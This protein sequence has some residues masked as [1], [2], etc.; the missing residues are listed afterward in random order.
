MRP[1]SPDHG[2]ALPARVDRGYGSPGDSQG[3]RS[4]RRALTGHPAAVWR[5]ARTARCHGSP[6]ASQA[7]S[8]QR[9]RPGTQRRAANPAHAWTSRGASAR[10]KRQPAGTKT[11]E[12][13]ALIGHGQDAADLDVISTCLILTGATSAASREARATGGRQRCGDHS[14]P[15]LAVPAAPSGKT[16]STGEPRGAQRPYP[17]VSGRVTRIRPQSCPAVDKLWMRR[18]NTYARAR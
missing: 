3:R 13:T 14:L 10:A 8:P 18:C 12:G 4:A 7:T 11:P 6:G 1:G 17:R 15:R 9:A 16:K 5:E 2:R